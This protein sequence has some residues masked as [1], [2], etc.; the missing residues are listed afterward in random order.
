MEASRI[1]A[2]AEKKEKEKEE[3]TVDLSDLYSTSAI[4]IDLDTGEVL[5]QRN[6]SQIIYPASLTKMMTVLVALENIEDTS[7]S[8]TLSPDIFPPLYEK[9]EHPWQAL[10]REKP[11]LIRISFMAPLLPSGGECCAALAQNIAGSE[12]A[13]VEKNE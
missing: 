11:P 5:A 6:P 9:R 8:V 1:Q 3:K 2:E 13:F 4:L 10:N 7:A 12:E